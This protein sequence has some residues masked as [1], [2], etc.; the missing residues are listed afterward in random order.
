MAKNIEIVNA[1]L[2]VLRDYNAV[3]IDYGDDDVVGV[4]NDFNGCDLAIY[5]GS[6]QITVTFAF[7][8]AE[9]SKTDVNQVIAHCKK[10]LTS[11]YSSM[12]FFLGEKKLFGGLR[13]SNTCVFSSFEDVLNCYACGDD[14][15]YDNVKNYIKN[16]PV[17]VVAVN[18]NNTVSKLASVK[19]ENDE[20]NFEL[21][22]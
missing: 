3:N 17:N 19:Y 16:N 18:F 12:E 8:S 10:I 9:F 20:F 7:H 22:R 5:V 2:D 15:V 14:S 11:E 1:L 13:L 6:E 4:A 21:L